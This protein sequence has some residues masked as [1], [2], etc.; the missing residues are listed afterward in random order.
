MENRRRSMVEGEWIMGK[1]RGRTEN[2]EAEWIMDNGG[3]GM[4]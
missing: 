1:G 4:D 3:G 2:G